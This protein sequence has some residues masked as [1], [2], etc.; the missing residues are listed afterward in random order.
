LS[1]SGPDFAELEALPGDRVRLF[2]EDLDDYYPNFQ[3]SVSMSRSNPVAARLDPEL[4]EGARA[5]R[6]LLARSRK[7]GASM[8]KRVVLCHQGLMIGGNNA[9]D[10]AS[11]AHFNL[12]GRN[13]SFPCHSRLLN[14]R[15]AP[16]DGHVVALVQDDHVGIA[17]DGRGRRTN[18]DK[19]EASFS[20]AREAYEKRMLIYSRKKAQMGVCNGVALGAEILGDDNMVGGQRARRQMLSKTSLQ[21]ACSKKSTGRLSRQALSSWIFQLRFRKP[22]FS[23]IQQ[24]LRHLPSE[25]DKDV[26]MILPSSSCKELAL[27]GLL[28]RAWSLG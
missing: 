8:L 1:P 23:I 25:E 21:M 2:I 9:P 15:V 20:A 13:G 14:N 24:S 7:T 5:Y 18:F 3:A 4:F 12:L 11:E 26:V 22:M 17:I 28:S 6:N 10:W 16:R 27:L 19:V